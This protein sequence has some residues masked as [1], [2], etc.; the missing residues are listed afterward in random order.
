MYFQ[1]GISL[2]I[3]KKIKDKTQNKSYDR[4]AQIVKLTY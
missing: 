1:M 4:A 2:D 3:L